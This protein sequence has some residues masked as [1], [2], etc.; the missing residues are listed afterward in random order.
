MSDAEPWAQV[1]AG[2]EPD[3]RSTPAELYLVGRGL[4][5]VPVAVHQ[6]FITRDGRKAAVKPVKA[7]LGP[8]GG[9]A[10]RLHPAAAE[11]VVRE[12]IKTSA[13][14]T[15]AT[16][17]HFTEQDSLGLLSLLRPRP[18]HRGRCFV[19]APRQARP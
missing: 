4:A 3:A 15:A 16:D 18:D 10:I 2:A 11:L 19:N 14:V 13:S 17:G 5:G 12:G 1:V 7:S 6:T 8:V 9:G